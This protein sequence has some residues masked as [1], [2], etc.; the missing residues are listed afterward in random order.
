MVH[1]MD[2][3][4]GFFLFLFLSFG[5]VEHAFSLV[6]FPHFYLLL[7]VFHFYFSCNLDRSPLVLLFHIVSF[8]LLNIFT[9]L[10][11]FSLSF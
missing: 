10:L 5:R 9:S 6:F 2:A 1:E 8:F 11:M 7:F 4:V 3:R